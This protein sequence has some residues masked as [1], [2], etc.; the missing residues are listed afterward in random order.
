M[1]KNTWIIFAV[2]VVAIL[3]GLVYASQSNKIDV[4]NVDVN[5]IQSASEQNGQIGDHVFGN[6]DSK[7][8]LIEYGDFQCPGC[9]SAYPNV[10]LVKEKYKDKMGFV[11]RNYP[12]TTIHPNA[13]AASAAAESAGLQGKYWEM[14]DALFDRRD[15]WASLASD[16]RTDAF[17]SVASQVGLDITKLKDDISNNKEIQTKITTD[18]A[19]GAKSNVTATPTFFV[20]GVKMTDDVV[21]DLLADGGGNKFMDYLDAR[22]KEA[23]ETPPSRQ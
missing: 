8:V 21:S 1:S 10:K 3:G 6:K 14:N 16:K 20:N 19:L 23:G 2:V 9:G 11:F 13:L 12:L 4:S 18:R 17:M 15:T 5:K 22:L 7:V